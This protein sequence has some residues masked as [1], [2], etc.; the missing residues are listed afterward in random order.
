MR[1]AEDF[2]GRYPKTSPLIPIELAI[3]GEITRCAEIAKN[4]AA[5]AEFFGNDEMRK[6]ALFIHRAIMKPRATL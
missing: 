5:Q 6:A 3:G 2:S 1:V 4:L